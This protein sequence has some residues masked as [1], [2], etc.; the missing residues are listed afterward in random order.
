MKSEYDKT[1]EEPGEGRPSLQGAASA[2]VPLR[3]EAPRSGASGEPLAPERV[4][5][6][7]RQTLKQLRRQLDFT[8]AIT[9]SLG[10]GV[11]ALDIAGRVTFL[12]PAAERMLGWTEAELLGK[13]MHAAIHFRH[14]DGTAFP[15]ET[16]PLLAVLH[17]GKMVRCDDDVFVRKDGS[18]LPIAYVS[19]PVLT[20][21]R[22][23]GAV[24]AFHDI[25]E[26]KDAEHRLQVQYAVTRTL[27]ESVSIEEAAESILRT[28]GEA[29]GLELGALWLVARGEGEATEALRC[30]AVWHAPGIR[31]PEFDAATRGLSLAL[32]VGLPGRVWRAA[33]PLR[34]PDLAREVNFPRLAAAAAVG[35]R[36]AFAF[37]LRGDHGVLGV[38]EFFSTSPHLPGEALL[39]SAATLDQQIGQFIEKKRAEAAVLASEARTEAILKTAPDGIITIDAA[40]CVTAFNPAAE[41]T[42][43]YTRAEALGQQIAELIIPPDLRERHYQG[44]RHYLAT[45]EAVVLGK[46]IEMRGMR[47]DGT[48]FPVEMTITRIPVAGP[49]IFTA[50]L[51]DITE[52]QRTE[53]EHALLLRRERRAR[54]DAEN[55]TT[56]LRALQSITEV[57]LT[58]ATLDELLGEMLVRVREVLDVDAVAILL[59]TPDG[60]ALAMRAALGLE[61][62]VEVAIPLGQ[63]VAG[64][65][66]AT[67]QPLVVDDLSRVEVISPRLREHFRSL[68]GVPLQVEGR[69]LGVM[70]GST[71]RARHFTA[72][73]RQLLQLVA[74]RVAVAVDRARLFEDERAARAAA[75]QVRQRFE[76]LAEAGTVLVSSLEYEHTL[77]QLA[78]M[79][80]PR[81]ADSCYLDLLHEDGSIQ[82]L[83]VAHRDPEKLRLLQLVRE[84][85]PLELS[86]G[87]PILQVLRTGEPLLMSQISDALFV[88][89]AGEDG[90]ALETLRQLGYTSGLS[91]PLKAR[92]WLVG[93]LTLLSGESGR[94]YGPDDLALAED[95]GRRAGLAVDNARLFRQTQRA[96]HRVEEIAD[97]L[98][99][100]ATQLD[101]V[102]QAIPGVVFVCDAQGH[103]THINPSGAAMLG[104]ER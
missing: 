4:A 58:Y 14:A 63:G 41:A 103:I 101:A 91:V 70:Y 86:P 93:A 85:H 64:R 66:A 7:Q 81:L 3:A 8:R 67:R 12:N 31:T 69:I 98:L 16:C 89:V 25:T 40:G 75:E 100:Q 76:F 59:L 23:T 39:Q 78:W 22:I 34:I 79:I 56:R 50:H 88:A 37:P 46:R 29:L 54:A 97:E 60:G 27:A 77:E 1:G 48:E 94:V 53:E 90:E 65:I 6:E 72:A 20:D 26:Q 18:T 21:G 17:S 104:L 42:F 32:G 95:L 74:D 61:E 52:R 36:A 80:V 62:E 99:M 10:E 44:L 51:R 83:A 15:I 43:G 57:S 30:A 45:G 68:I 24:L 47:A 35:L 2:R 49:P 96:L 28:I 84:R 73:E 11:Y 55:A 102:I 38:I 33:T 87:H 19:A 13:E 92:G 9:N 5:N 71:H 82:R